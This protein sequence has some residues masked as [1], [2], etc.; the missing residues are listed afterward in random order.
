MSRFDTRPCTAQLIP[1]LDTLHPLRLTQT[2][3]RPRRFLSSSFFFLPS[4]IACPESPRRPSVS[5]RN[6]PSKE[7]KREKRRERATSTPDL[8]P[9]PIP[10]KGVSS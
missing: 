8:R 6:R 4:S 1:E 5:L 10:A 3:L 2:Q 9:A 7:E